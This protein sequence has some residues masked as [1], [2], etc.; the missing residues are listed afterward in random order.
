MSTRDVPDWSRRNLFFQWERFCDYAV[1][2]SNVVP[3]SDGMK[4]PDVV[5]LASDAVRSSDEVPA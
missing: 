5:L 2:T 3:A 4:T 1:G